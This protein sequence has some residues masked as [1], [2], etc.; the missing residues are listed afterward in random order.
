MDANATPPP[1][2]KLKRRRGCLFYV[3]R[4]LLLIVIGVVVLLLLGTAYQA[5]ALEM[6][7][8]NY[9]PPGQ[10]Y[11]VNGHQM[12]INCMGE[13]ETTVVLQAGG[14]ADGLWWY[15]VQNQ[16]A[17]QTRV[18]AYDRAGYGWSE[19][20][21]DAR[22]TLTIIEELHTLLEQAG[23]SAPYVMAGHS[24]GAVFTRIYA[25]Q[26]P[27][28]VVGIVLVDS[29]V[30]LPDH[31]ADQAEFDQ[32][33]AQWQGA[34][35]VFQW[36]MRVGIARLVDPSQFQAAGYPSEVSAEITAMNARNQVI[37]TDFAE[38]VTGYWTLVDAAATAENLGD[39]PM[40]VLWASETIAAFDAN[41]PG[42]SEARAEIATYST[43]ITVRVIE[44]AGHTSVLGNEQYAQQVTDAIVDVMAAQTGE[45]L[46]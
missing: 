33:Q 32:W 29:A 18:C 20:T 27:D 25:A 44:G 46:E 3:G 26:Y 11:D 23:I 8:T 30:L 40:V 15:W 12:H 35:T 6:D 42:F 16:L 31:F 41:I 13:G 19:P 21:T 1:P 43:N 17:Q 14:A 39:L 5:V 24:Y 2:K 36:L 22:E 38:V 9:P 10:L 7:K 4:G 45:P 34:H 37:D 28:E